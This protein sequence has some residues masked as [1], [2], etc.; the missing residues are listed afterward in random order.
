MFA[1]PRSIQW[2]EQRE[3][4]NQIYSEKSEI[5]FGSSLLLLL[6]TN[7]DLLELWRRWVLVI[8]VSLATASRRFVFVIFSVNT[9]FTLTERKMQIQR[10]PQQIYKSVWPQT[11]RRR[12]KAICSA[13]EERTLLSKYS[14]MHECWTRDEC[15][16][17]RISELL[18]N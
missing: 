7:C 10:E 8:S 6:K 4:I 17:R 14:K 5:C 11:V 2:T 13:D 3:K 18:V 16:L 9:S 1:S 12:R 15:E